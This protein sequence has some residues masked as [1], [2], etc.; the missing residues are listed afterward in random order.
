MNKRELM[1]KNFLF[2]ILE[3]V[4]LKNMSYLCTAFY[5]RAWRNWQTH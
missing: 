4:F 1:P 3:V 2:F 5:L